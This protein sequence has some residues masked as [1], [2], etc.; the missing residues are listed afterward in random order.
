MLLGTVVSQLQEDFLKGRALQ[1]MSL[2]AL[3]SSCTEGEDNTFLC[4][5]APSFTAGASRQIDTGRVQKV[6]GVT[7]VSSEQHVDF[8]HQH[9]QDAVTAAKAMSQLQA[10]SEETIR[11]SVRIRAAEDGSRVVLNLL[12]TQL[13]HRVK[14]RT[15]TSNTYAA[16]MQDSEVQKQNGPAERTCNPML[17]E[18]KALSRLPME[19]ALQHEVACARCRRP[20]ASHVSAMLALPLTLPIAEVR[21]RCLV[22][23][24]KVSWQRPNSYM[25]YAPFCQLAS[26]KGSWMYNTS[27]YLSFKPLS[28]CLPCLLDVLLFHTRHIS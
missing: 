14:H 13:N 12:L 23:N 18:W 24:C 8:K 17:H 20:S 25:R 27:S 7:K 9:E 16:V 5:D 4:E 11:I 3:A 22:S 19:V 6:Q 15:I 21:M 28:S 10:P 2:S 26:E 1:L